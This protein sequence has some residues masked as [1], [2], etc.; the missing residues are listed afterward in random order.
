MAETD[1]KTVIKI[2]TEIE[3]DR[4]GT[5]NY[6][7][8]RIGEPV[9]VTSDKKFS[10]DLESL[11]GRP[12]ALSERFGAV[13][14]AHLNVIIEAVTV[15]NEMLGFAA[16]E[17]LGEPVPVTSDQKF[18]FDLESLPSRPF[19]LS[20]RFGAVFVVHLNG[21]FVAI[22]EAVAAPLE[23]LGFA[24]HGLI[25]LFVAIIDADLRYLRELKLAVTA[26][27]EML[28]FAVLE[29]FGVVFVAHLNVIA[30]YIHCCVDAVIVLIELG[31]FVAI[32][33]LLGFARLIRLGEPV[34]VTSDHNLKFDFGSLPARTLALSE[35]FG[36]VFVAHL[37][38]IVEYIYDTVIVPN[39]ILGFV[40]SEWF[41][42][43]FVAY[44]NGQNTNYVVRKLI[45]SVIYC[46]V[47]SVIVSIE[48][49]VTVPNE[50]LGFAV[51]ERFGFVFVAPLNQVYCIEVVTVPN[52]MLGF[53]V[54][55]RF[56][57]VFIARLNVIFGLGF[58]VA[59]TKDVIS[60]AL[61]LKG[62]EGSC[63]QDLSI[64]DVY[65]GKV[66]ILT[67]SADSSTLAASV[68]SN[69]SFFSVA[70]LLNKDREPSFSKSIN[71]SS[72]IK[73]MHWSPH[74]EDEYVVL[75]SA[76]KLYQG[77]GQN[78]LSSL[79][80]DVDAV[81]WSMNGKFLAVAKHDYLIILSSKFKEKLRIKLLFDSLVDGDADCVVKVDSIKWVR[82][83]CI[84]LGC[85]CLSA[86]G[87]EE[88][89]AVQLISVKDGKITNTS[90]NPV[91][92][93]FSSPYLAINEDD[94][95]S[96][97]GPYTLV[98]YLD[99][100]ELAFVA[101]KRNTSEHIVQ[102]VWSPDNETGA[103]MLDIIGGD[104]WMPA[105]DLANGDDANMIL[106]LAI[107]KV[108]QNENDKLVC[109]E[110]ETEVSPCCILMCLTLDGKLFLF[111]FASAVGPFVLP[112]E[113][114][115]VSDEEEESTL[116][117]SQPIRDQALP[118]S[119]AQIV[120]V[121]EPTRDEQTKSTAS[122]QPFIS[123]TQQDVPV[124]RPNNSKDQWQPLVSQKQD[125]KSESVKPG[126][127]FKDLKTSTES[128]G[129]KASFGFPGSSGSFL[130]GSTFSSNMFGVPSS[131][132]AQTVVQ[133]SAGQASL[134]VQSGSFSSGGIFSSKTFEVK[135]PQPPHAA[136]QANRPDNSVG[137]FPFSNLTSGPSASSTSLPQGVK[138]GAALT[139]SL[140]VASNAQP[141]LENLRHNLRHHTPS[142][143]LNS[144]SN[145]SEQHSVEEMAKE[146]D[147]L[148][149]SIER[150]GGFYHASVAAHEQSV[151]TLEEGIQLLSDR[152]QTWTDTL[153]QGNEEVQ[154]LLDKTVQV[155]ARKIYMEALVKQ[156]TD[157]Q[158]LDI[159]NRQ[160][161]SSELD[162]KRRHILEIN[163]VIQLER[164][165]NTL[166][167]E[168]FGDKSDVQLNRKSFHSKHNPPRVEPEPAKKQNVK[169]EL[170][171]TI[172]ISY[173]GSTF[174]SPGQQKVKEIPPKNQLPVPSRSAAVHSG[175]KKSQVGAL[176]SFEPETARRRRDSLDRSWASIEPP[177]TTVKRMLLQ[178]DRQISPARL[179]LPST[180]QKNN[181]RLFERS[182]ASHDVSH[183]ALKMSQNRG[184]QD[185]QIKRPEEQSN[186][187]WG[188]Y[189]QDSLKT[190]VTAGLSLGSGFQSTP[191]V[192]KD[193]ARDSR[194]ATAEKSRSRFS[195]TLKS[196]A[197]VVNDPKFSQQSQSVP[198]PSSNI[199]RPLVTS[200]FQNKQ[201]DFS[202]SG[203][204]DVESS[205]IWSR[206]TPEAPFSA[207]SSASASTA[208]SGKSFSLEA[209]TRTSQVGEAVSSSV[210]SLP[211]PV[212]IAPSSSL[213]KDATSSST[214]LGKSSTESMV[215]PV[216]S[217]PSSVSFKDSAS[218]TASATSLGNSSTGFGL[219]LGA[220][221]TVPLSG[222]S[223]SFLSFPST[224]S[225][226]K[227]S[228]NLELNTSKSEPNKLNSVAV[229]SSKPNVVTV[230]KFDL[231]PNENSSG[232]ASP[233]QP[234][235]SSAPSVPTSQ[236]ST[237]YFSGSQ[238]N[239]SATTSPALI[240]NSKPEQPSVS[241]AVSSPPI[242]NPVVGVGGEI[243]SS[244]QAVTQEDD[245]E[246][247]AP[248]TAQLTLGNLGGFGLGSS[249]NPSAPKQNPFGAP[250][251][252][253]PANTPI[254]S[255]AAS[256]PSGGLFKPAS[257]SIESQQPS[258]PQQQ[259]SFGAFAGGFASNNN[260]SAG[261]QGF[262]QP[263]KIGS[264]QQA[265]VGG[266]G[267]GAPASGGGGFGAP[268]TG[269]GGF[270]APATGGGGFGA[271]A[272]GGG[273]F[274]AAPAA[275]GFGAAATGGGGFGGAPAAGGGF[276]GAP[277]GGFGGFSSQ[278]GSGFGSSGGAVR[279]P[280]ELFTQ[281]RK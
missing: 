119:Q 199:A 128:S 183:E 166:E 41:G 204:K 237:I 71:G 25:G 17:R 219:N 226:I 95:P 160:K 87:Q 189:R 125:G 143:L 100:F 90:S 55:E 64:V 46:C 80:D 152:C 224:T 32:I 170:F 161:L 62:G 69:I 36:A 153:H 164:H 233:P 274:G 89:H 2:S 279:S 27:N 273:G 48:L 240:S 109:G 227:P 91:A 85:Y 84:M 216:T 29:R 23:L 148:L 167:L 81:N 248:D 51:W 194:D 244:D 145:L 251:G 115:S 123:G 129:N 188:N 150:P 57:V 215:V 75:T 132:S 78:D 169:K 56:G 11:P 45:R 114:N 116:S 54:L 261:G 124:V 18:I 202:Q 31:L 73:D 223:Q 206:K 20:V 225:S 63:I 139:K 118:Q 15:P 14:V 239:L 76:G 172:G 6:R 187:L 230:P 247:E 70:G 30:E 173:D 86:D 264:G 82:P 259:T 178:E 38:V 40:V 83:D 39:E 13:F 151:A 140:P 142:R 58:C 1:T 191:T 47:D 276:G 220:T 190:P 68:G 262:G 66:S 257:F 258:Q 157:S 21:P 137:K 121:N 275:G 136:T 235:V 34:P 213:L 149:D 3:G 209:F 101:N 24:L 106:G 236:P 171:D 185:A 60:S 111:H 179:S 232:Q 234:V 26:P 260:Q 9:P 158:Y 88:N 265:L 272:T 196:D 280:S 10:F 159:W 177:K 113:V 263:T 267:F 4:D 107:D 147:A 254:T 246:E 168:R 252:N 28:G 96:G 144:E 120:K 98:S 270:G 212:T 61:K 155:L 266:G 229:E 53:A 181:H 201:I 214:S 165:L 163:Q 176:K 77:A 250:F 99:E 207:V 42:V 102:F 238:L 197:G 174:S 12:F 117:S 94:I 154:L 112:E 277:A 208:F 184:S 156:A 186:S 19:A 138:T 7:F 200:K 52:E 198:E 222:P 281:M 278:G 74:M 103:E 105:I 8:N 92:L 271:P 104:N 126:A 49:A 243:N 210:A 162:M 93:T 228:V 72:C 249:P 195:F 130:S 193:A 217:A 22:I 242:S 33:E 79:L 35:W 67:L 205:S 122:S 268:A 146:L 108:N 192:T 221:Q 182:V 141:K 110:T 135:S 211:L 241:S 203:N 127:M 134:P 43:V 44:L 269:G 37:N 50:M 133:G 218:S 16:L 65:L 97:S 231:K 175:M 131:S 253:P 256:P 245:M 255:F 180:T 59:R 5:A